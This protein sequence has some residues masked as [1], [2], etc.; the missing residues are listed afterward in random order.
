MSAISLMRIIEDDLTGA[1]VA[2]LLGEHL[3][4]M[5]NHS[6]PGSVH[7]LDLEGLRAPDITFWTAWDESALLGCGAHLKSLR[8]IVRPTQEPN[9]AGFFLTHMTC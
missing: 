1:E 6:P 3:Q 5:F 9:F 8:G 4:C 7:A 2:A